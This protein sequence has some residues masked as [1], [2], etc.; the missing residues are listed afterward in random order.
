M[1]DGHCLDPACLPASTN[2]DPK[3]VQ[4]RFVELQDS[5]S[6]L[7]VHEGFLQQL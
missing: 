6:S 1:I 4:E 2:K 5:L 7:F 3:Q